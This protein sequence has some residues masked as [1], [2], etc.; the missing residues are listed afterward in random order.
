MAKLATNTSST[1]KSILKYF[2]WK[3]YLN[4]GVNTLGP[5]CLWQCFEYP[6][7]PVQF[8]KSSGI[9]GTKYPEMTWVFHNCKLFKIFNYFISISEV[10]HNPYPPKGR[11][12]N[13][14]NVSIRALPELGGGVY[15]CP[16]FFA[17]FFYLRKKSRQWS[18]RRKESVKLPELGGG[19]GVW[20]IR[21]MPELKRF[22]SDVFP[23]FPFSLFFF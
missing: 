7:P 5:L 9:S 17:P 1:L 22:F 14:K 15:P 13:K 6:N 18:R 10:F 2:S 16:N 3:I 12:Q 20:L 19:G 8:W 11:R 21:A 4:Y 23:K